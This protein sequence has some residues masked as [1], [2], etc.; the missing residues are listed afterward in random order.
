MTPQCAEAAEIAVV[1]R[2]DEFLG[3]QVPE[4]EHRVVR[5][6]PRPLEYPLPL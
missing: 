6:A 4:H 1:R 2:G 5:R 3:R